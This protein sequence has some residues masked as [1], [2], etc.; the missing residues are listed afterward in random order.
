MGPGG[1]RRQR[2]D[3]APSSETPG[4]YVGQAGSAGNTIFKSVIRCLLPV[5]SGI[6]LRATLRRTQK[7]PSNRGEI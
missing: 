6:W 7:T 2:P 5:E 1:K 3:F 4:G